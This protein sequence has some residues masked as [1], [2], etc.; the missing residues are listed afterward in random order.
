M[1]LDKSVAILRA[2]A[3]GPQSLNGLTQRTG[4]PRPTAHRLA[5]AMEGHGLLQRDG[6]GRFAIGAT[7]GALASI[8]GRDP[9]AEFGAPIL[10]AL[11]DRTGESCQIYRRQGDHRV[12]VLSAER[13]SGL[14]DTVP[15]G[16]VLPLTAGSAAQVLLAWEPADRVRDVL[17][18]AS[19]DAAALA[20]VRRRGW[21]ASVAEREPGVASVSA[22]IRAA[23]D[24]VVAALSVS[25]PIERFGAAPG[26]LH[27][28]AVVEAARQAQ[29]ALLGAS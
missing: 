7:I 3:E 18:E 20:A 22:P 5:V 14:R 13:P 10:R 8:A 23:D 19:F 4:I 27:A 1:V 15:A 26:Q 17:A 29:S 24:G 16:A 21:A 2:C 6:Q 11:R 28:A 25:G 9:L 12:C